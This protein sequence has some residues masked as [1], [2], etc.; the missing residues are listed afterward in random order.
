MRTNN[1]IEIKNASVPFFIRPITNGISNKISDSFVKPNL[2]THFTF[3]EAQLTTSGGKYLCG[4]N[5]TGADIIL[6]FPLIAG[7]ERTGM[8]KELYPKLRAYIDILE[9][10]PGYQKAAE[11]IIEI[12]GKFEAS[13]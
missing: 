11:K 3:L 1:L 9:A 5:L 6:S 8:S 2:K 13:M 12:D 10:E 4:P 7:R